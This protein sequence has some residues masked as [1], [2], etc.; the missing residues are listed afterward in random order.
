MSSE[1][2]LL[3]RLNGD[4]NPLYADP[5]VGLKLG[6]KG[7]IMHGLFTRNAA[8]HAL[9]KKFGGS[10]PERLRE[11]QARF[12]TGKKVGNE[13]FEEVVFV[14]KVKETGAAVLSNGRAVVKVLGRVGGSKL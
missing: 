2:V 10:Q 8:A 14:A 4:Y 13:G 6:F 5:S 12:E 1:T 9:L 3:Y 11:F 7:V